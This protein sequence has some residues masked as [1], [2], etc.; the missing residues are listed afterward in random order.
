LLKPENV[1]QL[2]NILKRHVLGVVIKAE[3]IPRGSTVVDTLSGEKITV[4]KSNAGVTI[5]SSK[6][7][8]NV[9][10]TNV[11]ASNGVVHVV[12]TVF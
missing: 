2:R 5:E 9:I 12:D 8:A 6:G 11:L 1:N 7:K 4:T 3:D 10:A